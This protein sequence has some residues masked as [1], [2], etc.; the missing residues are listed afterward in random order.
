[1]SICIS[2]VILTTPKNCLWL[3]NGWWK[4]IQRGKGTTDDGIFYWKQVS[5]FFTTSVKISFML[6]R[7]D[8]QIYFCSYYIDKMEECMVVFCQQTIGERFDMMLRSNFKFSLYIFYILA[9]ELQEVSYFTLGTNKA[10]WLSKSYFSWS[11]G[12]NNWGFV[13]LIW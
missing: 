4:C 6:S 1:M 3:Q 7:H 13:I 2:E 5:S 12:E 11:S 10:I 9:H 8:F